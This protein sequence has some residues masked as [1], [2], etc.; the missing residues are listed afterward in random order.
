[1]IVSIIGMVIGLI[2]AVVGLYYRAK[3]KNDTESV[4]IYGTISI[5]SGIVFVVML[6]KLL[7]TVL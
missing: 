3:E 7:I 4:K 1:M 5:I 2:V 6:V